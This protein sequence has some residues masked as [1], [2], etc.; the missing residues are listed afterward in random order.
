[1]CINHLGGSLFIFTMAAATYRAH[2]IP[3][4]LVYLDGWDKE[5]FILLE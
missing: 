4:V 5:S 2:L 3:E 1:M